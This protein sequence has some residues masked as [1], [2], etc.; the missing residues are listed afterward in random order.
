MA[1]TQS[2][3]LTCQACGN[4]AVHEVRYVGRLI[5][6]TVCGCCGATVSRDPAEAQA[7]YLRDIEQ[8]LLSKPRRLVRRAIHDPRG[9]AATLPRKLLDQPRKLAAE[10]RFVRQARREVRAE[11]ATRRGRR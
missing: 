8:R 2:A 5:V 6:A 1:M 7:E 9:F 11:R 10:W 4:L 3:Y